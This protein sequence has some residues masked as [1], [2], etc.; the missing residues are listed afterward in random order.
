MGNFLTSWETISFSRRTL[1]NGVSYTQ[2]ALNFSS[3][4]VLS[5]INS[6]NPPL[7]R[8]HTCKSIEHK[9]TFTLIHPSILPTNFLRNAYTRTSHIALQSYNS[10]I[11]SISWLCVSAKILV[12]QCSFIN[13]TPSWKTHIECIKSK[14]SIACYA[15]HSV[16]PYVSLNTLKM[17]Y[18]SYFHFV[19]T[20]GLLFWGHSSDSTKIFRLQK[21]IIR[22]IECCRTS[23]S[24][25]K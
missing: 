15:M 5:L 11:L 23:D 18:Y 1:L 3:K 12:V 9:Y 2:V 22:I 25:R 17:I 6:C 4:H 14:L 7:D 10:R 21:K 24:C 8:C 19:M 16:K 20:Y 13:K